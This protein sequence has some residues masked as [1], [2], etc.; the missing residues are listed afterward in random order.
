MELP[1]F[2]L[3]DR[4]GLAGGIAVEGESPSPVHVAAHQRLPAIGEDF[5]EVF[6]H[7]DAEFH[8]FARRQV[9]HGKG[10]LGGADADRS[11]LGPQDD[12]QPPGFP[13][14][15]ETE[16]ETLAGGLV[17]RDGDADFRGF[18]GQLGER[19]PDHRAGR[20]FGANGNRDVLLHD[21]LGAQRFEFAQRLDAQ[22]AVGGQTQFARQ[23]LDAPPADGRKFAMARG[24]PSPHDP[25]PVGGEHRFGGE[26]VLPDFADGIVLAPPVHP[27]MVL[28]H[29]FLGLRIPL[30][31]VIAATEHVADAKQ[32]PLACPELCR[33]V[34]N[35]E[36]VGAGIVLPEE[37]IRR[38]V[39][40]KIADVGPRFQ[41][42]GLEQG[43]VVRR[44]KTGGDGIV[45]V[46]DEEEV[47]IPAKPVGDVVLDF[48]GIRLFPPGK[49]VVLGDDDV[50]SLRSLA[51]VD[52]G[53]PAL[54]G[55]EAGAAEHAM[56][57]E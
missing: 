10:R 49:L 18:G 19:V 35:R 57:G 41:V 5:D 44:G 16:A 28:R 34:A 21:R 39:L 36:K 1:D 47:R 30:A 14:A 25:P 29:E 26:E 11:G 20:R 50:V 43:H 9:G 53:G 22:D 6:I 4:R 27:P 24:Q 38:E 55:D 52:G 31:D 8:I 33:G 46:A 45:G 51:V 40:E 37:H 13:I 48:E 56:A 17:A 3:L 23:G 7:E 12:G 42:L 2:E 32:H 15:E 54:L